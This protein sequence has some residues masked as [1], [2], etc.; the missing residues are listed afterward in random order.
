M[1]L[2]TEVL[3]GKLAVIPDRS[4]CVNKHVPAVPTFC[5]VSEAMTKP[6]QMT[7]NF[8]SMNLFFL[9]YSVHSQPLKNRN[10]LLK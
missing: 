6:V 9:M 10:Y 5:Y 1:S 3:P 4:I 8:L 2:I 7:L